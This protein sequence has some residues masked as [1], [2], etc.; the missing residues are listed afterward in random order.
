LC[1]F[2]IGT[3]DDRQARSRRGQSVLLYGDHRKIVRN[4]ARAPAR[5]RRMNAVAI[6]VGTRTIA[7]GDRRY[8]EA[9]ADFNA[10]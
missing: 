8:G 3:P 1:K 7:D 9:P 2:A 6:E 5:S 10:D 4:A